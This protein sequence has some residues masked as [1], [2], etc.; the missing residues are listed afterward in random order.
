MQKSWTLFIGTLFLF[1]CLS[2]TSSPAQAQWSYTYGGKEAEYLS[3]ATLTRDG[4]YILAGTRWVGD[5]MMSTSDAWIVK[6]DQDGAVMWQKSYG[7]SGNDSAAS[8]RQTLDGG[9]IVAGS[10]SSFGAGNDDAWI[11]KLTGDGAVE[12]QKTF[13]GSAWDS[14]LFAEQL[15]GG[16]YVVAGNTQSFGA[17]G[18]DAWVLHLSENGA[19][20]WQKTYGGLNNDYLEAF[21]RTRGGGFIAAGRTYSFG[22]V[23]QDI[24]VLKLDANGGVHWFQTFGGP[25]FDYGTS[26]RQTADD[27]FIVTGFFGTRS[28]VWVAK[29]SPS[30]VMEWQK[31]YS[32]QGAYKPYSVAQTDDGGYI[33]LGEFE[34]QQYG[35][36][37]ASWL[38]K[39]DSGG[40][41]SWMKTYGGANLDRLTSVVQTPDGG[42]LA[43]GTAQSFG[44]G[45]ND[46][47]VLKL[48]TSGSLG[49]CPFEGVLN[50]TATTGTA[51][52]SIQS[53]SPSDSAAAAQE[54]A[55]EV[56]TT[57]VSRG[58]I[59]PFSKD[60]VLK[61]GFTR[62]NKGEG[63]VSS[64]DGFIQC[65]GTCQASYPLGFP[66]LLTATAD[67]NS[68]VVD[69]KPKTLSC[70]PDTPCGVF[71]DRKKSVKAVFDGPRR[72]KVKIAS[73]KGGNGRVWAAHGMIDCPGTC[74]IDLPLNTDFSLNAEA[75]DT[76][77]FLGWS[78]KPCK[79][80]PSNECSFT[81][82]K[83]YTVK[84]IFE[85]NP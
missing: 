27:G 76:S 83:N 48:D 66:A 17:G 72:L 62:K 71:V 30:G 60:I 25:Y 63:T 65:P 18:G 41:V 24:W 2:L 45:W 29:L 51:A 40:N 44:A 64:L 56:T 16:S 78:G 42:Y 7:G 81:M 32:G 35:T 58:T 11:L 13:G 39:L 52:V 3:S 70:S 74:E 38:L 79:D 6:L 12:W 14:A 46:F 77:T 54:S 59:C 20:E 82:D 33:V 15:I 53:V 9:Y 84:A 47:W 21:Q 34:P 4:G 26:I 23:N 55:A 5:D 8:V 37:N 73:K 67:G 36:L 19:I 49:S 10:T 75:N 85:G 68:T 31:S 50:T 61:V 57:D 69:W 1:L 22:T 80:E 28:G 43:A